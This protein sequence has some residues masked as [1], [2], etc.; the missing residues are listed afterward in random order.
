MRFKDI[1]EFITFLEERGELCRVTASVSCDLEIAEIA[2]R[3]SKHGGPA[4]L[5][6]NVEGHEIPVLVNTYG[7]MQRMAWAMGVEHLDELGERV[8]KLLSLVQGPP[9][10]IIEKLR[11]LDQ[12]RKM[13]GYQPKTVRRASCQEVVLTGDQVDLTRLPILKCWPLDGGHL[14]DAGLR[15]SNHGD[16][17]ANA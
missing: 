6:E 11:T 12:L 7:S 2:D 4:L 14:S 5:F 10:G 1:R 3:M 9:H 13:A 16:A 17:L 8:G 15:C